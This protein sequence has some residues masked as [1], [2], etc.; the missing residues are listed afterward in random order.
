MKVVAIDEA[1]LPYEASDVRGVLLDFARYGEWFPRPFRFESKQPAPAVLVR[2]HEGSFLS[3]TAKVTAVREDQID[4]AYSDGSWRG[5]A[6]WTLHA[7]PNGT[8]LV[9]RVD[10]EPC[11]LW[12]RLLSR[13]VRVGARHSKQMK[14]VF[15]ALDKRLEDLGVPQCPPPDPP[16]PPPFA[17]LTAR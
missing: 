15:R 4:L 1:F 13:L 10:L 6:R 2:V 12:L 7:A 11:P 3:W 8:R 14:R 9:H 5:T 17:R 16:E